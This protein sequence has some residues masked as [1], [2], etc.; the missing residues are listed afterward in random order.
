[1]PKTSTQSVRSS[2]SIG[3][4]VGG[5][6][7][8]LPTENKTRRSFENDRL[9]LSLAIF[10]RLFAIGYLLYA[11]NSGSPDFNGNT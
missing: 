8:Y 9:V 1:M 2:T 5:W 11:N 4:L 6:K 3:L 7:V 10:A